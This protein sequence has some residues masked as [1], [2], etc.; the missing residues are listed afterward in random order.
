MPIVQ[1]K[2]LNHQVSL[3]TEIL[4]IGTFNPD[5]PNG[6]TFFYGRPRNFLWRLLPGCWGLPSL[7]VS[8]LAAK[9]A[10]MATHKIDFADIIESVDVP[11]G[12]EGNVLDT[13]IDGRVHQWRDINALIN[14][15]LKLKAVY[16]TRKTFT[17]IPNMKARILAI[18]NHCI[19]HNVRFCLLETPARFANAAKQQQ[20][21]DTITNQ[22]TCTLAV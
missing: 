14:T 16:C 6:P 8:P 18:Q 10:F 13:F 5:I 1:H 22:N 15:L 20:W 11:V 3:D 2:F 17:G 19:Q 9:F 4:I 12:Q 21:I 7:K